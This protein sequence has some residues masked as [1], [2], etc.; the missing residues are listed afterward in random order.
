MYLNENDLLKVY[1]TCASDSSLDIVEE[2]EKVDF[3]AFVE[4][5]KGTKGDY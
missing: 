5:T 3:N 1:H 2:I 4:K